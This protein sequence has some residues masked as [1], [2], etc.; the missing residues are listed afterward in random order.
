MGPLDTLG[1]VTAPTRTIAQEVVDASAA[2]GFPLS[3]L[4]GKNTGSGE[5]GTGRA[6][7]FMVETAGDLIPN[8]QTR[9]AGDFI[10]EYLWSNRDRFGL[11]HEIWRQR[12]RSTV[13]SPGVWRAMADRGTPTKNHI[14]HV[15]ALFDGRAVTALSPQPAQG[16]HGTQPAVPA[17][18]AHVQ[19]DTDGLMGFASRQQ[20]QLNAGTEPDGEISTPSAW[21]RWVQ[22]FLNARGFRD[23]DNRPLEIDGLGIRANTTGTTG[24]TRTTWALQGYTHTRQDGR[25]SGPAEG[26]SACI[27]QMQEWHNANK[28]F[29]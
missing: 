4:W 22:L 6:V 27:R 16:A 11:T 13:V 28:L 29:A 19:L 24:K 5:H 23:W 3:T 18:P 26:G 12:I 15:H 9:A 21:V 25:L 1:A 10:A 8:S 20:F 17:V 7:D 2:A 14:D